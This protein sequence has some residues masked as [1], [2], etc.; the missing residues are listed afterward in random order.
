MAATQVKWFW[1]G[2]LAAAFLL[3]GCAEESP[4]DLLNGDDL[5]P[6]VLSTEPAEGDVWPPD[7]PLSVVF[8]ED[9]K[10]ESAREGVALIGVS[11][12]V[13][14]D[15]GLRTATLTPDDPLPSGSALTL[16][17]RRIEDLADNVMTGILTVNFQVE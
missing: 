9:V 4:D 16:T 2:A 11:A 14:Y 15:A 13:E 7:K 12:R 6:T 10:S 1:A 8:N 5:P 17:V 3:L